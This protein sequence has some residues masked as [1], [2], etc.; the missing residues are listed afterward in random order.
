MESYIE[1]LNEA[2]IAYSEIL[3]EIGF[4]HLKNCPLSEPEEFLEL[5][6][7]PKLDI[8][9]ILNKRKKNLHGT[10]TKKS[11]DKIFSLFPLITTFPLIFHSCIVIS[12]QQQ[13]V[14]VSEP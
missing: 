12:K 11:C 3:I 2:R 13:D 1:F 8:L 7:P 14:F 4:L 10:K 5:Y 6:L 9:E